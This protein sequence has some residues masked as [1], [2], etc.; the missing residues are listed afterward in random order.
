MTSTKPGVKVSRRTLIGAALATPFIRIGPARAAEFSYKLAT[1]QSLTQPINARLEQACGR[2]REATNGRLEIRFFPASQLG[3]DTDL[4][5]QV[6]SGAT[7]FLNIAG[8]VLST[9]APSAAITN[10][11]FAFS[12]Y[13]QVWS[14]MDGNLGAYIRAQIEKSGYV[15]VS[16]AADNAFRQIT[17]Y[18]KPIK[19]PDDLKSYRIRVPVSGIFVSLFKALGASPTSINFNELYSSLQTHVVDGQENGLV[20]IEAGKLYEVQK[21]VAETNHIWDPFWLI[22]NRRTFNALP[23]D[24]RQTVRNEFDRASVE[25]RADNARLD[26]SLKDELTKKGLVFESVDQGAFRAALT[27]A[28][29]YKE[30]RDKFGAEAWAALEGVVGPLA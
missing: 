13:D 30:W 19:T 11:G 18:S 17:S 6:R 26:R 15:V 1:G 14:G 25:Q 9:I 8:S 21:Y 10:V 3:S 27:Q 29:F 7:E 12:N 23:E 22:A 5:S 4:L 24:L 28:G 2:I 16:K 20:T